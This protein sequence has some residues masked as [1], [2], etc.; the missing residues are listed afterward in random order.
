PRGRGGAGGGGVPPIE[1]AIA[2]RE[3]RLAVLTGVRPGAL[4]AD[5]TPRAYP[6]LAKSLPLRDPTSLLRRRPD[7]RAGERRLA[8]A[9]AREGI[10]AAD[11]FPRI[12]VTGFLGLLAGR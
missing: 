5:L 9:T 1:S 3:H 8:A 4:S 2:E 6:P 10:A 12:T 11:L 7:V